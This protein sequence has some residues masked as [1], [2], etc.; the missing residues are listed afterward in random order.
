MRLTLSI[1]IYIGLILI[2]AALSAL[3]VF[4]PASQGLMPAEEL[5]ASKPV[6][7]LA[8]FGIA[9][10]LYGGL[11]LVGLRLS[12]RIGFA[13]IW[14]S[15]I[16]NRQRFL[17]PAIVGTGIGVFFVIADLIFSRLH[18]FGPLPHPPFPASLVASLTA[19]I[20]EELL[21]RLFF[22]SFWVW[23]VSRVIPRGRWQNQLFW[24]VASLSALA[25]AF[26]HLPAMMVLFDFKTVS[27]IPPTL[28]TE[29]IILNGILSL[30]AAYYFRKSGFLAAVGI[31]FWA[32]VVW[33]V[34]WGAI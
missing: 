24:I 10:V 27:E 15:T 17:T 4:L 25:F 19:G 32:D 22:I 2:L 20:G 12:Q 16:S 23:L 29:I 26:G 28:L 3:S 8:N 21:F 1:K 9:L 14:D 34:I 18:P 5:P 7:A 31:H 33:H 30:F 11:G 6:L 13:D